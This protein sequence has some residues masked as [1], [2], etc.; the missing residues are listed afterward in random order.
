MQAR[1]PSGRKAFPSL[2]SSASKH[3]GPQLLSTFFTA[4]AST[5]RR[6]VNGLTYRKYKNRFQLVRGDAAGGASGPRRN[7]CASSL[8][9]GP[10]GLPVLI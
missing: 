3:P 4:A 7:Q 6:S 1:F 10:E 2:S 8:P 9:V 5:P